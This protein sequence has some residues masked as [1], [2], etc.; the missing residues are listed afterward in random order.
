MV[1]EG[2]FTNFVNTSRGDVFAKFVKKTLCEISINKRLK[3]WY[4]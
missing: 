2:V 3:E 4:E 1:G